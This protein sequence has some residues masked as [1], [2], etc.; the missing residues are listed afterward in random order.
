MDATNKS[1]SFL[2]GAPDKPVASVDTLTIAL[3]DPKQSH[4]Q[5]ANL[6]KLFILHFYCTKQ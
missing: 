3:Q 6:E 2:C 5:N 4:A 1:E